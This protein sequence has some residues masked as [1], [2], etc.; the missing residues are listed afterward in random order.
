MQRDNET[1]VSQNGAEQLGPTALAV[2]ISRVLYFVIESV[3]D[4]SHSKDVFHFPCNQKYKTCWIWL[5]VQ[6]MTHQWKADTSGVQCRLSLIFSPQRE[7]KTG[8][9]CKCCNSALGYACALTRV[10]LIWNAAFW[11]LATLV[12]EEFWTAISF[13]WNK[14][15]KEIKV[16]PCK[17]ESILL[18]TLSFLQDFLLNFFLPSRT[19][20]KLSDIIFHSLQFLSVERPTRENMCLS[21]AISWLGKKWMSVYELVCLSKPWGQGEAK[22]SH[23]HSLMLA[24]ATTHSGLVCTSQETLFYR[25]LK[26]TLST[27]VH[28]FACLVIFITSSMLSACDI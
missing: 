23:L 12:A 1:F 24:R 15:G 3:S 20:L 13:F 25:V 16:H 5:V 22:H 10:S 11:K 4:S 2:K 27:N 9:K 18:A 14:K 19:L 21:H 6:H 17:W 8:N 7:F 26:C 28:C